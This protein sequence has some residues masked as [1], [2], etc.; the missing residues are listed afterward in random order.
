MK[1]HRI[2]SIW[3]QTKFTTKLR[4]P[5]LF[6]K[7]LF[8]PLLVYAHFAPDLGHEY[9]LFW[10]WKSVK[11]LKFCG[12]LSVII[13]RMAYH[14]NYTFSPLNIFAFCDQKKTY[15]RPRSVILPT[16]GECYV[17]AGINVSNDLPTTREVMPVTWASEKMH[18]LFKTFNLDVI[19]CGLHLTIHPRV[20]SDRHISLL[21]ILSFKSIVVCISSGDT[22]AM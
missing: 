16:L 5:P 12:N 2:Y 14:L 10:S 8:D 7:S 20:M 1:F 19:F 3:T 11:F 15:Y 18:P 9:F 13:S 6:F 17:F 4:R 21:W 22:D